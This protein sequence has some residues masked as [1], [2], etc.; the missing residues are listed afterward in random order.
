MR[1]DEREGGDRAAAAG[2]HL[3][4]S[5][6]ERIDHGLD[7]L[8]LERRRMVDAAVLARA[9]PQAAGVVGDDRAVGELR[10][11]G[12]EAVGVH[13]LTDHHQRRAPLRGRQRSAH[14]VGDLG[15]RGLQ[16]VRRGHACRTA[17]RA[18]THR[19]QSRP[20]HPKWLGAADLRW[21][22]LYWMA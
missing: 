21:L 9:A 2:E 18:R 13:G 10:G 19:S 14:V 16:D 6:A 20:P 3:D 15:L 12:G 22:R 7:V 1:D 17:R 5:G 8:R 4:R 11:Q